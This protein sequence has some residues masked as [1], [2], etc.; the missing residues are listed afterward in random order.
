MKFVDLDIQITPEQADVLERMCDGVPVLSLDCQSDW[1]VA[2]QGIAAVDAYSLWDARLIRGHDVIDGCLLYVITDLGRAV[3][4]Q[5]KYLNRN[6][7]P[8]PRKIEHAGGAL[9]EVH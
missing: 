7:R 4:A 2:G 6:E 8:L 1:T 5:Y 3:L 9:H